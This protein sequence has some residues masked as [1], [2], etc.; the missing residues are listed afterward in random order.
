MAALT[1]ADYRAFVKHALVGDPNA[2][3]TDVNTTKDRIINE[4]GRYMS[5]AYPWSW[6]SRPPVT[7][8]VG[9]EQNFMELPSDFGQMISLQN[10]DGVSFSNTPVT[11][12]NITALRS[13]STGSTN[14]HLWA[15]AWPS[16]ESKDQLQPGPRIE[17][18]PSV[19]AS[20]SFLIEYNAGWTELVNTTDVPNIPIEFEHLF[21]RYIRAFAK[22]QD[23]EQEAAIE[24]VDGSSEFFNMVRYQDSVQWNFGAFGGGAA[25]IGAGLG[26]FTSNNPVGTPS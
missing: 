5:Y 18:Y 23:D 25:S 15:I 22:Q 7:V 9:T 6:R 12:S 10:N 8:T 26:G 13:G 11:L 19:T 2:V 14:F 16:Q 17:F 3:Y 1:L 24:A 20:T 21:Q 4:A